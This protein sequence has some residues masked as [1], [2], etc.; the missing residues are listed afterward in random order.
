VFAPFWL[1]YG[2]IVAAQERK[3]LSLICNDP[4][5]GGSRAGARF[6]QNLLYSH[7]LFIM[8]DC[9]YGKAEGGFE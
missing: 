2:K 1:L 4:T 7:M 3:H 9:K 5:R 6:R 8:P